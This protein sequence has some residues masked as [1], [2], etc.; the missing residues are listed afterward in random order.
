[1]YPYY[2]STRMQI[3][4]EKLRNLPQEL[5]IHIYGFIHIEDRI[6]ILKNQYYDKL[7]SNNSIWYQYVEHMDE[8]LLENFNSI[9]RAFPHTLGYSPKSINDYSMTPDDELGLYN[10]YSDFPKLSDTIYYSRNKTRNIRHPFYDDIDYFIR[11]K[12]NWHSKSRLL[13]ISKRRN[14]PKT[15]KQY[16]I[17]NRTDIMKNFEN[18]IDLLSWRT[19]DTA[20]DRVYTEEVFNH[21]RTVIICINQPNIIH[22]LEKSK[23]SL[24]LKT[25]L[26]AEKTKL[27]EKR[28]QEEHMRKVLEHCRMRDEI[29]LMIEE[30]RNSRK[31]EK[32]IKVQNKRILKQTEKDNA[33][34]LREKLARQKEQDRMLATTTKLMQ[35]MFTVKIQKPTVNRKSQKALKEKLKRQKE[36]D[37][38]DKDI[39]KAMQSI[40]K[41]TKKRIVKTKKTKII[42]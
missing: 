23:I 14:P 40:F 21:L 7:V 15:Y 41:T 28:K 31:Y 8:Q 37:R 6:K 24:K 16:L 5:K 9:S 2:A 20:F 13:R 11:R 35:A 29:S 27:E 10:E 36:Y 32:D 4:N 19:Y 18:Q 33:R 34:K 30:D 39:L 38:V 42:I 1:M 3:I 25:E 12:I 22:Q 26:L 17:N